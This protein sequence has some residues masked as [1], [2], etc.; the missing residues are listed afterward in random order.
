MKNCNNIEI[1]EFSDGLKDYI[2]T[3]NYNWL[4]KFFRVEP[5]D[6]IALSNPK[7]YIIDKGGYIFFARKDGE[8][9]GTVSLLKKDNEIFEIGKMAVSEIAQGFGIG[10]ILLEHCLKFAKQKAIKTL[11]LYSNTK[12]E[13]AIHLY[14]KYGFTETNLEQGHYDRANIKMIKEIS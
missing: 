6:E 5:G 2:K 10:T 3:L 1:I 7:E 9:F 8:I 13:P 11:I 4:Q 14:K 12:L